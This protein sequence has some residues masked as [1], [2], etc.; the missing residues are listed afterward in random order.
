MTVILSDALDVDDIDSAVERWQAAGGRLVVSRAAGRR[1]RCEVAAAFKQMDATL[2][3]ERG[4][5][6][7][8]EDF[9]HEPRLPEPGAALTY[10]VSLYGVAL[11]RV[12]YR[13]GALP[14]WGFYPS[15]PVAERANE[16]VAVGPCSPVCSGATSH[17]RDPIRERFRD[18]IR[19]AIRERFREPVVECVI[20]PEQI[21]EALNDA[22]NLCLARLLE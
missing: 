12:V 5:P 1:Q 10:A 11:G 6:A 15:A 7:E 14:D 18:P 16:R 22:A 4:F 20:E 9:D 3:A 21:A 13:A 2:E 19:D 17:V 8:L